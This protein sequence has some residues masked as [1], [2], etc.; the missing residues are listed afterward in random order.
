MN[1]KYEFQHVITLSPHQTGASGSSFIVKIDLV[2]IGKVCV[3]SAQP[4]RWIWEPFKYRRSDWACDD[5]DTVE[6]PLLPCGH[7]RKD[8]DTCSQALCALLLFCSFGNPPP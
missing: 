2:E 7:S 4:D 6:L 8:Y 3:K 1:S 5:E